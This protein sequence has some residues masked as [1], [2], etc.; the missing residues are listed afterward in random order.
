VPY[1]GSELYKLCKE[2]GGLRETK[3]WNEFLSVDFD[4]PVYINPL[5]GKERMKYFYKKAY[6]EYYISPSVWLNS[7]KSLL[8]NGGIH[9]YLRGINA[10]RSLVFHKEI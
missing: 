7:I 1:P 5:I 3:N 8:W 6:R 4:N 2:T 10:V 9:R